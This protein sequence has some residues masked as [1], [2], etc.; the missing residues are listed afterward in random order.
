MVSLARKNLLEDIPRFLVA[1]AGIM[2]AVSL[3]TLQTGIFNGFTYSSAQLIYN[4]DAD[5]WVGSDSIVQLELTLPIPLSHVRQAQAVEGVER[6]E[7]INFSG[8][9]W[10]PPE[11]DISRVRV[12][13]FNPEGQLFALDNVVEGSI[14]ALEEPYTIVVDRTN[15]SSLNVEAV[16]DR[17]TINSLPARIVGFTQGNNSIVS[18]A[19]MFTSLE[20]AKAF[21]TSGQTSN[22]T[23]TLPQ[24]SEDLIC[25]N[26]YSSVPESEAPVESPPPPEPL[27]ASDLVTFVL[28]R[29][30]PGQDLAVL[31]QRLE[32]KLSNIRAF[33]REE[34]IEDTQRFW[35]RR[36][37]VGFVLGLGAVVGIIVGVIVVSQILYSSVSDH[38]KEFGTLKAIG[39]SDWKIYGVIVEQSL[40]MA[41]LGY[42]PG[43]ALCYGVATW[44]AAT[45]GILILITP[46]SAVGVLALTVVMCIGSAVFA[47][48]KVTH[49]DPAMV[50]KA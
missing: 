39:A 30:E 36:T 15:L 34:L 46:V 23:C 10:R 4:S 31:K 32:E 11:G 21:L 13:G 19:F 1:Q 12:V 20:S 50:F 33:T 47:I 8:A 29:A 14:N 17:V 18:N 40:W 41:I 42:L 35:Q 7:G 44:T 6:A 48:Q 22:L 27:V 2:F 24:G 25:T 3:V 49:L 9:L 45:Q 38:L 16:G 5:I 37:G 43:M 26:T 28:V